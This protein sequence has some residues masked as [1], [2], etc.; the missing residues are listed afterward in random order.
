MFLY[1]NNI[2]VHYSI[3]YIYTVTRFLNNNNSTLHYNSAL[4]TSVTRFLNNSNSAVHS[5]YI[6]F[7][8]YSVS[9][10]TW[11]LV[12]SF[13]CL[14]PYQL[15]YFKD[16][17]QF[18]LQKIFYSILF[19]FEINFIIIIL[20]NDVLIILFGVKELNKLW[21]KTFKTIHQLS[22]FRG[23]ILNDHFFAA[24]CLFQVRFRKCRDQRHL[25]SE[26]V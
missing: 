20:P 7:Y 4:N 22:C 21:K 1:N 10:E 16:F 25:A 5:L 9:D 23:F 3:L 17:F 8:I 24:R 18:I 12:N 26:V 2:L 19:C 13:E 11:E 15:L 14:L 6:F